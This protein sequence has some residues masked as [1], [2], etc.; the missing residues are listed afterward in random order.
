MTDP[1][2][3]LLMMVRVLL[4]AARLYG[5]VK[6]QLAICPLWQRAHAKHQCCKVTVFSLHLS[7]NSHFR[8]ALD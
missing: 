6:Q 3:R 1:T 4:S 5:T 8:T 7:A 2:D